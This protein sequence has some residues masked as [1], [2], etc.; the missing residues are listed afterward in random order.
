MA[1][2]DNKTKPTDLS[3]DAFLAG[4]EDDGRRADAL[5]LRALL[6]RVSGEPAVM[7]GPS[8]VGCGA[9]HYRY[10]SGRE[11]TMARIGFSPRA[12]EFVLYV[13][14]GFSRYEDLRTRLGKHRTGKACL[15]VK[16]LADLD[17]AVLEELLSQSLQH[18]RERYPENR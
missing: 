6:E 7:W 14:D 12:K 17:L 2:A 10:E 18:S 9:Y 11:G 5:A 16:R 4:I 1:K 3:V 13:M 15:Y 8:I